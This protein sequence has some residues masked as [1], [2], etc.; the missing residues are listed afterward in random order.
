MVE[1]AGVSLSLSFSRGSVGRLSPE[2]QDGKER[3]CS[4]MVAETV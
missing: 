1:G 4:S 2:G 3:K